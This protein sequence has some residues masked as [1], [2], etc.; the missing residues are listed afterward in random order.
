M[1]ITLACLLIV[2][3]Q[4][5]I[6]SAEHTPGF[7]QQQ[8]TDERSVKVDGGFM[9]SYSVTIPGTDV[10]F[11]MEPIPGGEFVMG[12]AAAE[13]GREDCEGPQRKFTVEPFW[14]A[15]CEVTWAEYKKYIEVY[16]AFKEFEQQGIRTVTDENKVDAITAPT[17]LYEPDFTFEYGE[18]DQ[19]P[20]VTITQ[21]S[22]KQYSKWL[23]AITGMQFRLPAEAEWE[24]ACRAGSTTA[25]H[26]GDD[27]SELRDYAWFEGNSD[28]NGTKKVGQK[29]PNAWG[30]LD[31]HGN[32]A[33]WVLDQFQ[34]YA[35]GDATLNAATDWVRAP[36]LD[37]RIVRGGSWQF[38]A[39]DCRSASRFPS[40]SSTWKETDPNLPKSPWWYTDDPA[41]G[42]GFRLIR[43]LKTLSREAMEEFWKIDNEDTMY[44]V[45]DRLSEGRGA[46]GIVDRTLPAAIEKLEN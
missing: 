10:T 1:R 4:T 30:L 28:D 40:D 12:S 41:R 25:F 16:D 23:S 18:E 5:P 20:A 7:V 13:S 34:P 3:L 22:A 24:Y 39:T 33:E 35:A 43:P 8:P 26:F 17:P 44:D 38:A 14:M 37:P 46:Q 27:A 2:V 42:V 29:K 11:Q 15:R 36:K 19:Q 45:E 6:L 32:A 31:M 9:V 21:Y